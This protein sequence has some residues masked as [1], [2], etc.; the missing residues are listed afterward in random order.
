[1]AEALTTVGIPIPER[2]LRDTARNIHNILPKFEELEQSLG[3]KKLYSV[4]GPLL[5]TAEIADLSS[6]HRA[7]SSNALCAFIETCQASRATYVQHALL[8]DSIWF[9]LLEIFLQ[10]SDN[11]KGKSM[12][13]MLLALTSVLQKNEDT[14]SSQLLRDRAIQTFLDI[15]CLR[16]DRVKVK[17]ALQGLSHFLSKDVVTLERLNHLYGRLAEEA[18]GKTSSST[19]SLLRKLLTWT[20]HHDT[21]LSAGHLI[22]NFLIHVRKSSSDTESTTPEGSVRP[23]WIQPVVEMLRQWPD[24]MQEFKTHVFPHCFLPYVDEYARFLSYLHF[25]DHL[26]VNEDLPD[27]LELY[28]SHETGLEG[29]EEFKILLATI[30]TGKE[31]GIVKDIDFRH[32]AAIELHADAIHI[33]DNLFAVWLS[34]PEP[35]IRLAGL[36]ISVYSTAVTRPL[37]A[38]ILTSIKRNIV[39][40][41]TDTDANFRKELLTHTQRLFDRLRGSTTALSKLEPTGTIKDASGRIMIG[42]QRRS[43]TPGQTTTHQDL[44]RES[45]DFISWYLRFLDW[46]LRSTASYQR[47]ITALRCLTIVLRSGL[48]PQVPQRHLSKTAQGQLRWVYGHHIINTRLVRSMLDLIFDPFDDIRSTAVA[49]L[50]I[51]FDCL[52]T[53]AKVPVLQSFSSLLRRAKDTMLRT[54]RADQADGLARA[55]A[56]LFSHCSEEVPLGLDPKVGTWTK[57]AIV[58]SLIT[59]LESTIELAQQDLSKAVNGHPV[60][61]IFASLRYIIDQ[62]TFYAEVSSSPI[63]VKQFWKQSHARIRRCI[64]SLWACVEHVLCADAP[65]GHVPDDFDEAESLDTK[66]ILSYSWRGLKEASVLLRTIVSRAPIGSDAS[67]ILTVEEFEKLGK[68]C[69]TQLVELRHRG[70]FSTVAQTFAAFCRRCASS[71]DQTLRALPLRW[72][73]EALSSIQDKATSI[74]RRSAGIPSLI[75]GIV[76]SESPPDPLFRRAMDDLVKELSQEAHDSNIE[77]SRLP[78]VHALNSIK[79]IYTTSKLSSVSESYIGEGLDIAARTLSSNVWPIR[80]CG[81]MLFKAL[82]ERLLG[83]DEA[84]DWKEADRARSSRFSYNNYPTLVGILIGLLDPNGPLKKSMTTAEGGSP[85]DLHGAEGVFPALQI[86]RQA[87]PPEESRQLITQSVFHLLGSP[88]WH[89]RDMAARTIVSLKYPHEYIDTVVTLLSSIKIS[90]TSHNAQHGILS[91]VKYLL[92]KYLQDDRILSSELLSEAMSALLDASNTIIEESTCPFTK[93]AFAD[94]VVI[95]GLLLLPGQPR[96]TKALEA[97]SRL[98]E[99]LIG[100]QLKLKKAVAAS[101]LFRTAA[102]QALLIHHILLYAGKEKTLILPEHKTGFRDCLIVESQKDPDSCSLLL[103]SFPLIIRLANTSA[104]SRAVPDLFGHIL[105]LTV[106]V[107]DP[108]VQAKA[109]ELVADAFSRDW[110]LRDKVLKDFQVEDLS[111]VLDN[112]EQQSLEGSPSNMQSALHLYGFL[113]DFAFNKSLATEHLHR[114]PNYIRVLRMTIIDTNPFDT[115]FAAVQSL[116]ALDHVWSMSIELLDSDLYRASI[117]GLSLVLYDLLNDDDDEVRD[118]AALTTSRLLASRGLQRHAQ[119]AVPI[120]AAQRLAT[121]LSSSYAGSNILCKEG[122]RR[123]TNSPSSGHLFKVAFTD[124]LTDERKEDDALFAQEKQNLFKDDTAEVATWTRV[125]KS[126][127]S[128]ATASLV[129]KLR[130]WVVNALHVLEETANGEVDGA[131]GWLS[132]P[133]VFVLVLRVICAAEVALKWDRFGGTDIRKSLNS[134]LETA[135]KSD[136]HGLL[137]DRAEKVLEGDVVDLIRRV[138]KGLSSI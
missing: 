128:P 40:L 102:I 45:M 115:R 123:L 100:Q 19:Q 107:K 129:V 16:H 25:K 35:E 96:S 26:G 124:I 10:R 103:D 48:D 104:L 39:H 110:N 59:H 46:E 42:P 77:E 3:E 57:S 66:E 52:S 92:R 23:L 56:L 38:G 14:E 114:L 9:R 116:A 81:L 79:E 106:H 87:P 136:V 94:L 105:W 89:L 37:T 130:L 98:Y 134:F 7:A 119:P 44:L 120:I 60:H 62:E 118:V 109:Q 63:E 31:L 131:L 99:I 54:G 47:R 132:K 80:N 18:P 90:K 21:A 50:D 88:H 78:Q 11:A 97:W 2:T 70:A 28:A 64:E 135:H 117:L 138:H 41:H 51:C 137:I 71:D 75:T 61:G 32:C 67:D 125:L 33:P 85:M 72:Y 82:I 53:E 121:F 43:S 111:Q 84:Q 133:E 1:M 127:S 20:V 5:D 83:S 55:Y 112:L 49:A 126:L 93:A 101:S 15:I 8:S 91:C 36:F 68:S 108:E 69:F 65:E 12:R 29:A 113:L 58:D 76:A 30:Q 4:V 13:H 34:N 122:L 73:Q 6:P 27:S 22:R 74:T 17:P 86:L 24:R 95:S